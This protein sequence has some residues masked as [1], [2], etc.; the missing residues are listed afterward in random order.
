MDISGR[1]PEGH[2]VGVILFLDDGYLEQI[3]I[4]SIEG[5][6]FGGLPE[7]AELEVWREGEL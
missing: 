6:D 3:E 5:D 7:P 2:H 4:Y 1:D